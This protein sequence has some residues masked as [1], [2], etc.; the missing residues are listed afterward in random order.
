MYA[1]A[2]SDVEEQ[3]RTLGDSD[4]ILSTRAYAEAGAVRSEDARHTL[5]ELRERS[6][7]Q[8]V[9]PQLLVEPYIGLGEKQ[10][11]LDY[12]EEAYSQH[13]NIITSLK[14][15]PAFDP[16]RNEPRFQDLP[17]RVDL[18]QWM[19]VRHRVAP[20]YASQSRIDREGKTEVS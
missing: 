10:K 8:P 9:D 20:A 15:D 4:R 11:T 1:K 19:P 7:H 17:R 16:L 5:E 18:A 6:R 12:L 3:R 14:V 2:L 13:S